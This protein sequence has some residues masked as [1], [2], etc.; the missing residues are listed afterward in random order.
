MTTIK[1]S[2]QVR[3]AWR[4]IEV[5]PALA[6]SVATLALLVSD[7]CQNCEPSVDEAMHA[8]LAP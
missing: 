6:E 8:H 3:P 1:T 7:V 5:L 4:A 2:T